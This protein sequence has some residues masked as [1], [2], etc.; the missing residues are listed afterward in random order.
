[1]AWID[2]LD[3]VLTSRLQSS[4]TLLN[5]N[6]LFHASHEGFLSILFSEFLPVG[7]KKTDFF[8]NHFQSQVIVTLWAVFLF[9]LVVFLAENKKVSFEMNRLR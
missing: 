5:N 8:I 3:P 1:M 6:L 4:N 9:Q 7:R 2:V